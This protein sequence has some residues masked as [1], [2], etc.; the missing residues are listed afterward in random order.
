MNDAARCA[1]RLD[2]HRFRTQLG[3]A[4]LGVG[5][6]QL[7]GFGAIHDDE[8]G[9]RQHSGGNVVVRSGIQ[10]HERAVLAGDLCCGPGR[11]GA[12]LAL[13]QQRIGRGD[14]VDGCLHAPG[15]QRC[16][17]ARS[18]HDR[19]VIG[20]DGDHRQAGRDIDTGHVPAV[21][22]LGLQARAQPP[23]LLVVADPAHHHHPRAQPGRGH[24]LVGTLAAAEPCDA[25][26]VHR[27][28]GR[29]VPRHPQRHI[30]VQ[31]PDNGNPRHA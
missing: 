27:L 6:A 28:V 20:I 1:S 15:I 31:A 9:Q 13:Q 17:G 30:S 22:P 14:L 18:H 23:A 19:H 7:L 16:V 5:M 24:C 3:H 8:V 2:E 4:A 21:D 26:G 25:L 11:G 10:H 12:H 29:R